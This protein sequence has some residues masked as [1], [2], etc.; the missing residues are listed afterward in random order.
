MHGQRRLTMSSKSNKSKN[1]IIIYGGPS[2]M[3]DHHIWRTIIYGGPS[4]MEDHHIWRT[5]IY[6]GPSYMEDHHIWRTIIY[7]GPSY[8]GPSY[9][10]DHHIWRTIIY[11]GPSYMEDHHIWRTIIYGGSTADPF[12]NC[13]HF[14]VN[15]F[16]SQTRMACSQSPKWEPIE[17]ITEMINAARNNYM[18]VCII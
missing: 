5:I 8:G 17:P 16:V 13:N 11:G 18:D 2:Y 14:Q 7:G 9:M 4:Y 12:M 3:E 15:R 10:E 6:G 1:Q